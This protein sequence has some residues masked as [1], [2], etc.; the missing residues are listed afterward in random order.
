MIQKS[1]HD[2]LQRKCYE[3]LVSADIAAYCDEIGQKLPTKEYYQ[4]AM[5]CRAIPIKSKY[6]QKLHLGRLFYALL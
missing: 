3:W 4:F 6:E 5:I 1:T 2:Y